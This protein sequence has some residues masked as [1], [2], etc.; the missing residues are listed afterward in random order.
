MVRHPSR[1]GRELGKTV[2]ATKSI[3]SET[4]GSL[5][6]CTTVQRISLQGGLSQAQVSGLGKGYYVL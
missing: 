4:K 6:T 1:V 3:S 2:E 5:L